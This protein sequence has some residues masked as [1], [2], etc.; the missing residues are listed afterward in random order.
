MNISAI[1]NY[2]NI[3]L[4]IPKIIELSGYKNEYIARKMEMKPQFFSAKKQK[5]SFNVEQV[6][7]LL[8]IIFNADVEDYLLLIELRSRK[9][10]E[11]VT[12]AEYKKE[13]AS[14]K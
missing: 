7:K 3:V 14:W 12:L 1:N 5:N 10:D 6:E 11:T 13:I 4:E 9:N 8:S 2:K